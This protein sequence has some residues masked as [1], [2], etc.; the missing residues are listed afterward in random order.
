MAKEIQVDLRNRKELRYIVFNAEQ[1]MNRL[2][3]HVVRKKFSDNEI[4]QTIYF[5]NDNHDVPFIFSIKARRYLA[6]YTEKIILGQD[7]YFLDIKQ[8]QG[9]DKQK[10]RIEGSLDEL[11]KIINQRFNFGVTPLRPFIAVE[12]CRHHYVPKN[13]EHTRLTLDNDLR[14]Y[15]FP[16]GQPEAIKIGSENSYSILEMKTN[17]SDTQFSDIFYKMVD[18]YKL[19]PIISKKFTGYFLLSQYQTSLSSKPFTKEIKDCEIESKIEAESDLLF[20]QIKSFCENHLKNFKIPTHF[21]YVFDGAT[22]NRYYQDGSG[23]FKAML[24]RDFVEIVRKS[25]IEV[26]KDKFNLN[27]VTKRMETKG[28]EVPL[29]SE[30]L[31]SAKLQSELLRMRKAF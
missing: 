19:F 26:I 4:V 9:A 22:I 30:I 1:I 5:N 28:Q 31:S 8:G 12:Y 11:T 3:S 20:P 10:V 15:Y 29:N 21:P 6:D 2:A 18:E 14:Y 16:I 7:R 23:I 17:E 25:K 24:K 27:C 13:N